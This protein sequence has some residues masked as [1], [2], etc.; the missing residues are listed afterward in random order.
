MGRTR[1]RRDSGR[2]RSEKDVDPAE[3]FFKAHFFQDPVQP[4]SLGVEAICQLLQFYVIERGLAAGIPH[5]RFEPV[6]LGRELTWK[7]RGQ[8]TPEEPDDPGGDGDL[9]DV[10]TRTERGPYVIGDARLWGDDT[11][12]RS[13]RH[14]HAGRAGYRGASGARGTRGARSARSGRRHH[15]GPGRRHLAGGPLPH[16]HAARASPDVR[17]R[18]ARRGSRA[19]DRPG[20]RRRA[21]RPAAPLDPDRRPRPFARPDRPGR[22][23][24]G[25]DA[26]RLADGGRIRPLLLRRRG[27][28]DRGRRRADRARSRAL[29]PAA[30]RRTAARSLRVRG[31]GSADPHS[32][33]RPRCASAPPDRRPCSTPGA[34]PSR[35]AASTRGC[36]TPPSRPSRTRAWWRWLPEIEARHGRLSAAPARLDVHGELPDDGPVD[37]EAR[38]AA[39]APDAGRRRTA[40]PRRRAAVRGERVLAALR[41][42]S[43]AP[44]AAV[45]PRLSRPT[46]G[47]SS[48]GGARYLNCPCPR[49]QAARHT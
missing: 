17:G 6:M 38:L 39:Y 1:A 4:G 33:T 16:V 8:I 45:L 49:R 14:R 5:P 23:R 31:A 21:R 40:A 24:P 9:V 2:L 15:V 26:L 10:G 13:A 27:D 30:G 20:G 47:T 7:Y 28:R 34:E 46:A 44:D 22:G 41:F 11:H 32:A 25:R 3:W 48:P 35:G 12:L 36:W 29:R 43:A 18:P 42:G 37:V 19:R